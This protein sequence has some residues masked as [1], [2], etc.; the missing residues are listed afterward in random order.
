MVLNKGAKLHV[1]I[2]AGP[3]HESDYL[4]AELYS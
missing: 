2:F 4:K 1:F 3:Y